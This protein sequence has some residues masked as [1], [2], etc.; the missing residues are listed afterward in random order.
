M[1]FPAGLPLFAYAA[2]ILLG[3]H[4]PE[5]RD[6]FRLGLL[7]LAPPAFALFLV[8]RRPFCRTL[9]LWLCLIFLAAVRTSVR[10][11]PEFPR[12]HVVNH[13]SDRHLL[14]EGVLV[15]QPKVHAVFTHLDIEARA[16]RSM[17]G[18]VR[19]Q[20]RVALWVPDRNPHIQVGDILLAEV[21]L[22]IPRRF[23]N[24]GEVNRQALAFLEGTYVR[25][26]VRDGRHLLRLGVEKGHGFERLVQKLRARLA[27][28]F[29]RE[30]DPEVRGLLMAWFLG[31]RSGLTPSLT[32]AFRSSGLSHLLAI[33]GLHVG[34]VGLFTYQI[35]KFLLKRSIRILVRFSVEKIA[36]FGCLPLVLAYV[37]LAGSPTSAVRAAAMFVLFVGALLL[38]RVRAPWN[39]LALAGLSI[40]LWDPAALFSVS[41]LL[42]FAAV[43]G[44]L[45][46]ASS[47]KPLPPRGPFKGPGGGR[48]IWRQ[49]GARV[50]RLGSA[51]LAATL[52]TAPLTALY[53][54]RVTPMAL[55]ANLVVVPFVGWCVI[56]VGLLTALA[57]LV[58]PPAGGPLLEATGAGTKGVAAAAQAFAGLPLASLR[59][60]R[61][62]LLEGA[63]LCLA[64]F[65]CFSLRG[66]PW[67]K[68]LLWFSAVLFCLSLGWGV[69]RSRTDPHL[70]ITFLSVGQG[71]SM[72]IEFPRGRRMILDGGL[73][74]KG[75]Q[76][77]GSRVVAP[78]LG[79]RRICRL[80]Y[81]AASHGQADHYGGLVFLAEELDP[82]ELWIGPE[83]GCEGEGY[84]GFLDLCRRKGMRIRRLCQGMEDLW[85]NGVRVEV[86]N[87]PCIGEARGA[88]PE[89]C[90]GHV[91]DQSLVLRLTFR[92]VRVLLTGDIEGPTEE[93]LLL[94]P[95]RLEAVLL[96]VPHH[97]SVSSSG[98]AFLDAVAP[99]LAVV[100][101]GYRNRFG[102]PR[103]EIVQRYREMGIVLYRTDMDGA[104]RCR[105]DG[106]SVW[107]ESFRERSRINPAGPCSA[108]TGGPQ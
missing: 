72:L 84:R 70:T 11:C 39:S 16:I 105:T 73:A 34:L 44:L 18:A 33:S 10:L 100:S 90:A 27:A 98:R 83:L 56:P 82:E 88:G 67:R 77:A 6:A 95:D 93:R 26:T 101:A 4:R 43:A 3:W 97:G 58:C 79:H 60:G 71:D 78:F 13:V 8:C 40:L 99:G 108:S 25:G 55:F 61:P 14:L 68:R 35:L 76:D 75:Y 36:L 51:T 102:F 81:L 96:K 80:D 15:R 94:N 42:S 12:D 17:K 54:N 53:F 74:R 103:E 65:G 52:A 106:R 29:E 37:L 49:A 69:F 47:W 9:P 62:S 104:V 46:A 63:V 87:P 31:D 59:V 91:N 21:R 28:F 30:A 23:G 89:D 24:P 66:S 64:L 22:K 107:T 85:V 57:A 38:D 7:S 1:I 19:I 41:F 48:R 5:W 92:G 2:G 86:L 50:W 20:G 45:A 32:E